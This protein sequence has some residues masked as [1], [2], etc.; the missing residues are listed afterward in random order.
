MTAKFSTFVIRRTVD[1]IEEENQNHDDEVDLP[2]CVQPLSRVRLCDPMNCSPTR[3]LCPWDFPGKNTGLGLLFPS[4]DLP[5]LASNPG[6]LHY[7]QI[8]YPLSHQG[9][10]NLPE[11]KV[12]TESTEMSIED[13]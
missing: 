6:L 7:R 11:L 9:S 12:I 4:G 3:L 5:D 8:F 13:P 10:P 1:F 2:V